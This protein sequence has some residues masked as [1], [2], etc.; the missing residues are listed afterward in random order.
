MHG[1]VPHVYTARGPE[2]QEEE[3]HGNRDAGRTRTRHDSRARRYPRLPLRGAT[4]GLSGPAVGRS[5][6]PDAADRRPGAARLVYGLGLDGR[7]PLRAGPAA[8]GRLRAVRAV[9]VL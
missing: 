5:P 9:S 3:H 8:V 1:S 7:V 2:A 6:T 4:R